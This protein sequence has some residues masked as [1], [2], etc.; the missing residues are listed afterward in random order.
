MKKFL[1][2]LLILCLYQITDGQTTNSVLAS[3]SWY[4]IA[5][6]KRGIYKIDYAFL[7]S[8]GINPSQVNPAKIRIYGNGG[9]VLPEKVTH[10]VIDD[11]EENSIYVSAS[12]STFGQNDYILFYAKGPVKWDYD[13][14]TGRFAHTKNYYEDKSYYFL[15][16]DIGNGKRITTQA[17]TGTAAQTF[18]TFD[19]YAVVDNDTF[20]PSTVGKIW[21]GNKMYNVGAGTSSETTNVNMGTLAGPVTVETHAG[22][23]MD[24]NGNQYITV[25][26]NQPIDTITLS[27]NGDQQSMSDGIAVATISPGS[28]NL[29]IQ[30]TLRTAAAGYG[31]LDYIRL[32]AQR[33]LS[34]SNLLSFRSIAAGN[35]GST[36]NAAFKISGA[37]SNTKVWEVTNPLHPKLLSG[38]SSGNNYTIVRPGDSLREFIMYDGSQYLTPEFVETVPNQNL[39]AMSTADLLIITN[40][41][42]LPAANMLAE[43]H[44]TKDNLTVKV[45]TTGQI[46]NEFSSGG[47]DIAGI[48]NFIKMFYD[49]ATS[50]AEKPKNVLLLGA[51]SYDYK[52]RLTNNTNIVPTYQTYATVYNS[53]AYS[54]DDFFALLDNGDDINTS[55]GNYDIGV[56]RIPAFNIDEANS[57][58]AKIISYRDSASFGPWKNTVTFTSD[59]FDPGWSLSHTQ[60]SDSLARIFN[61]LG[62]VY[63]EVKLYGDVFPLDNTPS[64]P[65][66]VAQA[67]ALNNQIYL[68]SLLVNYTGHGGP[69]V[70][71]Q[72]DLVTETSI[73][74]WTNSNKLP[75]FVTATCDFGRYDNPAERS[76]GAQIMMKSNGG[77]IASVTTTQL[78][79]PDDNLTFNIAY[80][81]S[82]FTKQADGTWRTLG[83][84][85]M[86]G[87]NNSGGATQNNKKYALLGDPALTLALP[88]YTVI[89]DS[90]LNSDTQLADTIGALGNYILKGSVRDENDMILS[91]FNGRAYVTIYD[92]PQEINIQADPM[93][94]GIS[95]YE[96]QTSTIY[97]GIATVENGR[98]SINIIIPK[99]INYDFGKCKISYYAENGQTDAAGMDTNFVVGGFAPGSSVDNE[100]PVVQPFIDNDKFHDGGV[101]GPD[102]LLFVKL[103]DDNGINISGSS[104]GHDLIAILDDDVSHPFVLNNYYQTAENDYKNGTVS[105]PMAGIPSGRHTVTVKA[106]DTYNNSGE[107]SISFVVVGKDTGAI[108]EVYN[109]PNPFHSSTTFVIQHNLSKE[110]LAVTIRIYNNA[111]MLARTL[112]GKITPEGNRTEMVWNGDSDD[113]Y[114]MGSGVYFYKVEIKN[115]TGIK[116][117]AQQ[118]LSLLR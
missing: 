75:V 61:H 77:S 7:Q 6:D 36:G 96:S 8:M 99:D 40:D 92:K 11:L 118:K 21:W 85:I 72:E 33:A 20:S 18:T 67:K 29:N 51:A 30:L 70:L 24:A 39:H 88:K 37:N 55:S 22:G 81:Q 94:F 64:G 60:Q 71:A 79:Y 45:A 41:S 90:L 14:T 69:Q 59:N 80:L 17:A 10:D 63:N 111:G 42:L 108:G 98:F 83:E 44:S 4:K 12:G 28:G 46:Y 87:K 103:Y 54:S 82:Q 53:A 107:G 102:P 65:K 100:G 104:V 105:F 117:T 26:N 62:P 32:N 25:V 91:G 19:D 116:A 27:K 101:T 13:I 15:N 112:H 110:D 9:T 115:G 114:A 93:P 3:G 34:F 31:Y 48:R 5:A 68:G 73:N 89:T 106:W 84:A 74:S 95:E 1:F 50:E 35:L 52:D 23:V 57:A 86:D 66:M 78:V 47:Q 109:Y 113:G 43:Y 97:K 16:F 58:V 38:T 2:S 76:G 49:R 56:G